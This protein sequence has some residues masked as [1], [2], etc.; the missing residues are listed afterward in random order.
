MR[1]PKLKSQRAKL[2][3]EGCVG[4]GGM[5]FCLPRA[6]T[7]APQYAL[8]TDICLCFTDIHLQ[9]PERPLPVSHCLL[10]R[11][12]VPWLWFLSLELP[13]RLRDTALFSWQD[14]AGFQIL[15]AQLQVDSRCGLLLHVAHP[16]HRL[17]ASTINASFLRWQWWRWLELLRSYRWA[18]HKTGATKA[19]WRIVSTVDFI[20]VSHF[21]ER[22]HWVD[23]TR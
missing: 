17:P 6:P 12:H 9:T 5:V 2:K 4:G 13:P 16:T 22:G 19:T 18:S 14:Q 11:G 15:E 21:R 20:S 8:P 23:I 7:C 10:L 3:L 1:A